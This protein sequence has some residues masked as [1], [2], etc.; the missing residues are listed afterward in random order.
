MLEAVILLAYT[1][2]AFY[3][4]YKIVSGRSE[5]LDQK[6]PASVICKLVASVLVGYVVGAFYLVALV[7]KLIFH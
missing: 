3:S 5:W 2:W 6:K 7:V 4:G 1:L